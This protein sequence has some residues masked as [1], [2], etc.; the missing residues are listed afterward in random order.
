VIPLGFSSSHS[1][2][3]GQNSKILSVTWSRCIP[4]CKLSAL[5]SA[6]GEKLKNNDVHNIAL[7]NLK[8]SGMTSQAAFGGPVIERIKEVRKE[9]GKK[10]RNVNVQHIL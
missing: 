5:R 3:S 1:S 6:I 8:G 2:I 10:T 4:L 7:G 9:R